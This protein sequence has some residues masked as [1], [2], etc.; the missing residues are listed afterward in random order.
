MLTKT[1]R[2]AEQGQEL[3]V[4]KGNGT[5]NALAYGHAYDKNGGGLP[6]TDLSNY[7]KI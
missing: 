5:R 6:M 3:T 2:E 7:G 1:A 4:M